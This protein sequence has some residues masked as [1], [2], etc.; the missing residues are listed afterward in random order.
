MENFIR[1]RCTNRRLDEKAR[2]PKHLIFAGIAT[3]CRL[4]IEIRNGAET[5]GA[6]RARTLSSPAL[7]WSHRSC[8]FQ[9]GERG[10]SRIQSP[11]INA[12]ED[13]VL[14]LFTLEP[15]P[16]TPLLSLKAYFRPKWHSKILISPGT[17]PLRTPFV[18]R[19]DKWVHTGHLRTGNHS[20]PPRA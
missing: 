14:R 12:N 9:I 8:T 6:Y 4:A 18:T 2:A 1:L 15:S 17:N 20:L 10:R 5:F 16:F 7:D 13:K 3:R 11:S 19:L